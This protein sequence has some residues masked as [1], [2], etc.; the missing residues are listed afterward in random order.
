MS[1]RLTYV[2]SRLPIVVALAARNG[3]VVV[4]LALGAARLSFHAAALPT[5]PTYLLDVILAA[6][7]LTWLASDLLQRRA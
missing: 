7:G 4:I 6:G 5:A 2:L 1:I 3:F